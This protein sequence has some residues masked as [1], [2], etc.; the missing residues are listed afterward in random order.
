[1]WENLTEHF[2]APSH[3]CKLLCSCF[4]RWTMVEQQSEYET[5]SR[6]VFIIVVEQ[7]AGRALCRAKPRRNSWASCWGGNASAPSALRSASPGDSC[8]WLPLGDLQGTGPL[9][10]AAWSWADFPT[11]GELGE[12]FFHSPALHGLRVPT[13]FWASGKTSQGKNL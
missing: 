9:G 6:K 10:A 8:W 2:H 4:K 7:R 12:G 3:H 1:M 5:G 11:Q 13:V